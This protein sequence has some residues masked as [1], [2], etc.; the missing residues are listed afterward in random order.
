[1]DEH[2]IIKR[3][4]EGDTGSFQQIVASHTAPLMAAA[5]TILG[6]RQDAEDLCQE[7]FIQAY[8]HLSSFDAGRSLRVWLYTI[9]YRR[10][11]NAVK[12]KKKFTGILNR[13]KTEPEAWMPAHHPRPGDP[14]ALP[15]GLYGTLSPRERTVLSLWVNEDYTAV[16][17]SVILEC[18]PSTARCYLFNI[19]K[20]IRALMEKNH[21]SLS[22]R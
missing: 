1:M 15:P 10:C 16:E 2:G 9:L 19:R 4:L 3:C 21:E 12:R 11:L 17:I 7:T 13:L 14:A 5:M 18:S 20:K 8:R 6:N 22:S